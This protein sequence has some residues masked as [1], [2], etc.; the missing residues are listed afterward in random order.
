MKSKNWIGLLL[1]LMLTV[2]LLGGCGKAPV[3]ED[4]V[5]DNWI[6]V[7]EDDQNTEDDTKEENK[8]DDNKKP[9]EDK[10]PE[11]GNKNEE[12]TNKED[13]KK[14]EEDT[15]KN[16][17]GTNKEENKEPEKEEQGGNNPPEE[18]GD[19]EENNTPA[20][21]SVI[22]DTSGVPITILVQNLK[23]SGTSLGSKND[24]TGNNI[25]N[26]IR[27]FKT[28]V[29]KYDPD[30]ILGQEARVGWT[31]AFKSDLFCQTYEMFFR[32]RG[33]VGVPGSDEGT[34]LQY[35]KSKFKLLDNGFFWLSETPKVPSRFFD[36]EGEYGRIVAWAKLK[37][38]ASGVE[39]YC[40]SNHFGFGKEGPLKAQ[41]QLNETFAA[42]PE[43][44]YAFVGGDWNVEY[45]DDDYMMMMDWDRLIDLRD[46]SMNLKADGYAITFGG[47]YGST[48]G[49]KFDR[50]EPDPTPGNKHQI[51]YLMAKP[52]PHMAVDY[53]GFDYTPY[54]YPADDI[55]E[56]Y[57]SDH[58]GLVV[59]LRL[60]TDADYSS[61]QCEHTYEVSGQY[62]W[63]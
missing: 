24:G 20:G 26:R 6:G 29:D 59:K 42:L 5:A 51:D 23:H 41:E 8:T 3:E 45:R 9:E 22:G 18:G 4:A 53:Y 55:K 31:E 47:M 25:Y 44:S 14:P 54:T 11:E 21:P 19:D 1:I 46:M 60:D 32:E 57:I 27:R 63:R 34:T 10:K 35:K 17:E 58:Y 12:G 38:K 56:G 39:F 37:D 61:Y 40:Y 50:E 16:E 48:S 28:M 49:G 36:D 33:P 62:Y 15:N 43:G 13:E 7:E 52:N 2:T 30:I